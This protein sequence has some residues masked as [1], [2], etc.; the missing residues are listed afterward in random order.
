MDVKYQFNAPTDII[1]SIH[2]CSR[3]VSVIVVKILKKPE[4][5]RQNFAK[6]NSNTKFRENPS[7]G[8]PAVPCGRTH[9]TPRV[10][11]NSYR[12]APEKSTVDRPVIEPDT[13]RRRA[14]SVAD[15]S[16]PLDSKSCVRCAVVRGL[17]RM[18][19]R[20]TCVPDGQKSLQKDVQNIAPKVMR[21]EQS[22][23]FDQ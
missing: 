17:C 6:K 15:T 1:I 12:N 14:S 3:K 22:S 16:P 19:V 20:S 4:C 2:T 9:M 21:H 23:H 18:R 8:I 13:S 5:S 11:F 10:S 7:S